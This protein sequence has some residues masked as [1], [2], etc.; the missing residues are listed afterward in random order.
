M[1]NEVI[2]I[3]KDLI[4]EKV[5]AQIRS[6]QR[7]FSI[8]ADEL[9]TEHY[10]NHGFLALCLLFV[11]SS[12]D[13]QEVLFDVVELQRT[14]GA[15]IADAILDSLSKHQLGVTSVCEQSYDGASSMSSARVGTQ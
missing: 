6:D 1:Q 13:I 12:D 14:T 15:S 4:Q 10:S 8:M 5:A 7:G 3:T 11:G 9:V 2:I